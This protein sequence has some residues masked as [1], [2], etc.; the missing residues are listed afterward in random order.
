[1]EE[2]ELP[3]VLDHLL[4]DGALEG[5]VE[6]LQCFA[7]GEPGGLDPPLTAV[8]LAG[9]DLGPEQDL[10][11]PLIA[12]LL[13]TGTVGEHRQRPRGRWRLERPEQVR[14]L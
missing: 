7:G 12:P 9:G 2:V 11:E 4:L 6:L 13:L 14:E 1:V 5:E 8:T 3:E 10:G